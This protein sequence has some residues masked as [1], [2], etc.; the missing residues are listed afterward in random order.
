MKPVTINRPAEIIGGCM[1]GMSG[2]VIGFDS[3]EDEVM[4]EMDLFTTVVISSD[5]IKQER[6]TE[7]VGVDDLIFPVLTEKKEPAPAQIQMVL[8]GVDPVTVIIDAEDN[9]L[10]IEYQG[11][12]AIKEKDLIYTSEWVDFFKKIGIPV[13]ERRV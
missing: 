1:F 4:I 7:S 2:R 3:R 10:S 12:V 5:Y 13:I 6:Y 9:I 8:D 11:E